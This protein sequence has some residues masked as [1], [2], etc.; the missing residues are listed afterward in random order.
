MCTELTWQLQILV[1]SQILLDTFDS[2]TGWLQSDTVRGRN[3]QWYNPV[4]ATYV[5]PEMQLSGCWTLISIIFGFIV[6]LIVDSM[7]CYPNITI[8]EIWTFKY[9]NDKF[10]LTSLQV[11]SNLVF[12][13]TVYG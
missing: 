12:D 5:S 4:A 6:Q 9:Q 13:M 11:R 3:T 10:T 8:L 2:Y 1:G 7:N